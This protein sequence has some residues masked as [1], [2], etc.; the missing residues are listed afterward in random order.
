MAEGT[1]AE[2]DTKSSPLLAHSSWRGTGPGNSIRVSRPGPGPL[3]AAFPAA[4]AGSQ[5]GSR[6][7]TQ[8]LAP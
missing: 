3:P 6:G 5:V 7:E 2:T 1:V 8:F 4:L